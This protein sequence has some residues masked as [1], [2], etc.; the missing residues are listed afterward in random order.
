MLAQSLE[1]VRACKD[2]ASAYL[3]EIRSLKATNAI[4]DREIKHYE[5]LVKRLEDRIEY[6]EK[7]KCS[8]VK[9]L[10]FLIKIRWC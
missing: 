8:E 10:F 6:L 5:K 7:K 2:K 1:E 9:V 4:S 3:D